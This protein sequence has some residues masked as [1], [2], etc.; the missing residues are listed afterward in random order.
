MKINITHSKMKSKDV[1]VKYKKMK[2]D[3]G[4]DRP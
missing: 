2:V 1:E 4:L 3:L